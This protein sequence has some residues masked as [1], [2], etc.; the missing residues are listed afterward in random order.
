MALDTVRFAEPL[1]RAWDLPQ[2]PELT[3]RSEEPYYGDWMAEIITGLKGHHEP[4]EELVFYEILKR[5]DSVR[6]AMLELGC[7]WAYYSCWFVTNFPHGVAVAAEPDLDHLAVG[8]R[9]AE[10]NGLPVRF[11]QAASARSGTANV[12]L[13]SELDPSV[14]YSVPART[15]AELMDLEELE[16]V[17]VLHLDI[18]GFELETLEATSAAV[19]AGRIRFLVVSTHH[20]LICGNPMI[21]GQCLEWIESMNGHVIAEHSVA[22]SFSGDGLIAASFD[23]RDVDFTVPV[24]VN[25]STT[26]LFQPP[27][28][29][30][31]ALTMAYDRLCET[32]VRD[33]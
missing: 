5:I 3:P 22:E 23:E 24:S 19:Q 28:V 1:C 2:Q 25:R 9:N 18:Q 33:D 26:S 21:H 30:L 29:D 6:P 7:F 12:T 13:T 14:R 32:I 8:R 16:R 11:H 17:D 27:E 10:I 31:A 20:H 15:P 4:Q